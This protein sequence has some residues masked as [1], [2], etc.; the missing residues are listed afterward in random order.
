MKMKKIFA[1]IL[2]LAMSLL[3][4]TGCSKSA[5]SNG[6]ASGKDKVTQTIN[7]KFDGEV[8]RCDYN[9]VSKGTGK[10][11]SFSV[12]GM[13]DFDK[14]VGKLNISAEDL[15]VV[16]NNKLYLNA[17]SVMDIV[18]NV[19]L[20]IELPDI[21][22]DY[23]YLDMKGVEEFLSDVSNKALKV[24]FDAFKDGYKDIATSTGDKVVVKVSNAE[25][26]GKFIEATADIIEDNADA[27]ADMTMEAYEKIDMEKLIDSILDGVIDAMVKMYSDAGMAVDDSMKEQL[28]EAA[29]SQMDTSMLEIKKEDLVDAYKEYAKE[30]RD[31]ADIDEFDAVAEIVLETKATGYGVEIK[32]SNDK[33]NLEITMDVDTVSP[34]EV[35]APAKAQNVMDVISAFSQIFG[36]F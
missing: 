17:K 5:K 11:S 22:A 3:A 31:E 10:T 9:I 19:D 25:E 34:V 13:A 18:K 21:E 24:Y 27:W 8:G 26:A 30:L 1:V 29:K 14:M 6:G 7:I 16:A 20:D 35:K 33:N 12:N 15:L 23:L 2:V 36:S 32:V 4:V 28:K